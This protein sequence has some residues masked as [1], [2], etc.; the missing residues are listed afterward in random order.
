MLGTRQVLQPLDTSVGRLSSPPRGDGDR[1]FSTR[2]LPI[3]RIPL[4]WTTVFCNNVTAI[5]VPA[6]AWMPCSEVDK[7][8]GTLELQNV[9]GNIQVGLGIEVAQVETSP[10]AGTTL[11][12]ATA[13]TGYTYGDFV[14]IT[15]DTTGKRIMRFVWLCSNSSG[16]TLSIAR[17]GGYA[18]LQPRA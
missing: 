3:T 17:V 10:S 5:R 11:L 2:S 4:P 15:S 8:M 9:L 14:S 6:T 7:I 13:T 16:S 12:N 1:L 18:M